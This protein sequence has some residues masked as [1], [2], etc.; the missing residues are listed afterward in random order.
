MLWFNEEKYSGMILCADGEK[1]PVSGPDFIDGKR[2]QGR[3]SRAPVS[4]K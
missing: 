4:S 1:L 3:C 2:P